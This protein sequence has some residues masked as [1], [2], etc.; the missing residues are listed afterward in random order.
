MCRIKPPK[1]FI[2]KVDLLKNVLLTFAFALL[3][4]PLVSSAEIR[5]RSQNNVILSISSDGRYAVCSNMQQ[6]VIFWNLQ[7]HQSSLISDNANIYSVKWIAHTNEFVWQDLNNIVHVDDTSGHEKMHFKHFPV[8]GEIMGKDLKTYFAVTKD[9]D[10][11]KGYGASQKKIKDG[12]G[13]GTFLS[14]GKLLNLTLSN[15]NTLLLTSGVI[16]NTDY[17]E[18]PIS[19]GTDWYHAGIIKTT[20][21]NYS[22]LDGVVLWNAKTGKPIKKLRGNIFQTYAT[23]SPDDRYIVAGDVDSNVF[24][25]DLKNNLKRMK[26]WGIIYGKPTKWGKNH[27]VLAFDTRGLIKAPSIFG[28]TYHPGTP[29]FSNKFIDADH[30]LRFTTFIP[31]DHQPNTPYAILYKV[32]DPRPLK[33][34]PLGWKPPLVLSSYDLDESIDTSPQTHTLIMSAVHG[35][36]VEYK[37]NPQNQ[38]LKKVWVGKNQFKH[39]RWVQW[40]LEKL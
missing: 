26:L 9:Y 31:Y 16:F 13:K 30:Y 40:F 24:V 11:Y 1:I 14:A 34:L 25:W 8:Y 21:G 33:Y 36:I 27:E 5:S 28:S 4:S 7:N 6:Q 19:K 2:T 35:G 38:T 20:D 37:Y 10:I 23:M 17:N 32:N 12:F 39:T 15:N 22:L 29:V 18:I 3:L